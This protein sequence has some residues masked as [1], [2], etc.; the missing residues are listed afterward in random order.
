VTHGNRLAPPTPGEVLRAL[1]SDA[2]QREPIT[3][4]QLAAA[5]GVSR[6]SVNQLVNDRRSV[7]AEMALRLAKAL[8]TTPD[9]W[10]NLQRAVDLADAHRRIGSE[11]EKVR[12]VRMQ[13]PE[14]ELFRD[15]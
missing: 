4:D 7:T 14:S 10:L 13:I 8:S 5:M 3:Q 9:F 11:L 6:Y 2:R 12:T 1:L 15:L